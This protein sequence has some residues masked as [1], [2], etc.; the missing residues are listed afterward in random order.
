MNS[1]LSKLK[2]GIIG[3]GFVGS[4][5]DYGFSI[6]VEKFIHDI[7]YGTTTQQLL[8]F[9]PEIVFIALPTP[10]NF[11]TG[12][13]DTS[14]IDKVIE[15][16]PSPLPFELVIKSTVTPDHLERYAQ[17]FPDLVYN[18]EFLTE[19]NAKRD[20]V[21]PPMHILGS[22]SGI[23]CLMIEDAYKRHSHCAEAPFHKVDLKT[24]S[25]IKYTLNS[26]LSVKVAFF[27]ELYDLFMATETKTS[28]RDFIDILSGD[29]RMGNTHMMV[30]G[31]DGQRGFGGTCFPK[32]TNAL[33]EYGRSIDAP[34][35]VLDEA[36]WSN[37]QWRPEY[38]RKFR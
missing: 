14:I 2:L 10:M 1:T 38:N 11:D 24:A 21:Q 18:P 33:I 25:L 30:P 32:D 4:A 17:K 9:A 22:N 5:I 37:R 15:E 19:K 3:H 23:A 13:I 34:M 26:F 7:K 6:N 20:F 36:V 16:L 29:P 8:D 28:Y 27:N 35:N 31:H 12:E